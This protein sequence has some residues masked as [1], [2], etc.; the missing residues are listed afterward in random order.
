MSRNRNIIRR[1]GMLPWIGYAVV[2]VAV[3]SAMG[4]V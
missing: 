3:I 1:L 2:Y 4:L